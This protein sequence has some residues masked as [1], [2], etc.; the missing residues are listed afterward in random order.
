MPHDPRRPNTRTQEKTREAEEERAAALRDLRETFSTPAGKRTLARLHAAT[1]TSKPR[2][3]FHAEGRGP[4]PIAAAFYDG[5]ASV[6][7]QIEADLA[8]PED[9]GKQRPTAIT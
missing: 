6:I 8:T 3:R 5:Q 9:Q 2:F 1:G 4:N 7:L